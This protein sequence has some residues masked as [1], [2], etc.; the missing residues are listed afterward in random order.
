M[1]K[2]LIKRKFAF[3]MQSNPSIINSPAKPQAYQR[4]DSQKEQEI[5]V[6]IRQQKGLDKQQIKD[7]IMDDFNI[8][9]EDAE[10]L[11]YKTYPDGLSSQEEECIEDF[12]Q[13]LPQENPSQIIDNAILFIT[14]E[15]QE[16][17]PET[18]LVEMDAETLQLFMEFL[19]MALESRKLI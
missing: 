4:F 10:R 9:D 12:E 19:K 3:M 11:Y 18:C 13:I 7:L 8:S 2:E 16:T 1:Y 15:Q 5:I 14:E 6:W 17:L